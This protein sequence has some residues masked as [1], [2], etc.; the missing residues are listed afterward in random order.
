MSTENKKESSSTEKQMVC[1][2]DMCNEGGCGCGHHHMHILKWVIKI[3]ILIIVFCFAF[4]MG[5]LKG[6][7]E[8]RGFYAG[9]RHGGVM[10]YGNDVGGEY[11]PGMMTNPS[12]SVTVPVPDI[13]E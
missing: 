6:M 5:E 11:G 9:N 13:T 8:N 7:L 12:A 4:Q 3:A 1:T 2:N 10:M